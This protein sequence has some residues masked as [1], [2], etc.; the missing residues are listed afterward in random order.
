MKM[1]ERQ[2]VLNVFK[3]ALLEQEV[4]QKHEENDVCHLSSSQAVD[5]NIKSRQGS[6]TSL[7]DDAARLTLRNISK[8]AN[9]CVN[10]APLATPIWNTLT[11]LTPKLIP[12]KVVFLAIAVIS[13]SNADTSEFNAVLSALV[14][15]SLA[16]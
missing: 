2:L 1:L 7:S 12:P 3:T 14:R 10:V 16:A 6:L 9:V 8:F 4:R 11:L 5:R 13:F 15:V